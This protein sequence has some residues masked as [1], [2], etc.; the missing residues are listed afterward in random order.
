M[1]NTY[2]MVGF[3]AQVSIAVITSVL[4]KQPGWRSPCHSALQD[5]SEA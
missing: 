3:A 5:P 2:I 4:K 1:D